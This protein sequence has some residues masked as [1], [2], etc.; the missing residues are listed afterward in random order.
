M[1][2][3]GRVVIGG[4]GGFMGAAISEAQRRAGRE[5]VTIGRSSARADVAWG[6]AAGIARAIDGADLVIGL[7]GKSVNCRYTA[8]NR[9][10]ILR[11]RVATTAAL[12][13]GIA[14]AD[15][16]P[17]LWINAATATI[18]RH[19]MD[20]PQTE[21]DGELGTGFSVDVARAW[22]EELFRAELP[23]T[24]RVAL[25]TSIV[26]GPGGVL[27][28]LVRLARLGLGGPQLDGPWP[29]SR[30]RRAAGTAHD[31]GSRG[32]AQR[33]SWVHLDDV[34]RIVDFVEAHP[35]LSGPVNVASP[36]PSDNRTLMRLLREAV[37]APVGLPCPRFLLE[38]GAIGIRTET[39][40]VLKSRWVLPE[41]LEGAGFR[42]AHPEL[43]PALHDLLD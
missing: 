32:G 31:P 35:E 34:I 24:R 26:L 29:V 36:A 13:A 25:R 9:A 2:G 16:P 22:E 39:E 10:E 1:A 42:F 14:A 3:S 17:P 41:R 43:G 40:L 30:R 5:V 4:A 12:A 15:A 21:T 27:V 33:F 23:A 7:A 6:D 37:G 18:Y 38:L 19:A 8:A 20:R 28:P 11:S